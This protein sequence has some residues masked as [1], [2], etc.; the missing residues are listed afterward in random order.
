MILAEV[1]DYLEQRGQA[2]LLEIAQHFDAPPNALRGMLAIWLRKN[3]IHKSVMTSACGSSCSQC[4]AAAT[5]IYCWGEATSLLPLAV[6]TI[7][8]NR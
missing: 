7:C 1:K 2:S 5:E 4:D 3:V 6:P 8:N